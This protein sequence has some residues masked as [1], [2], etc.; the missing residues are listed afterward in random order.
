ME[1]VSSG[2]EPISAQ[3]FVQLWGTSSWKVQRSLHQPIASQIR[4]A[5]SPDSRQLA[6]VGG[7][8]DR[9]NVLLWDLASGRVRPLV[10]GL[11]ESTS[12]IVYDPHGRWVAFA[13]E[14]GARIVDVASGEALLVVNIAG[15]AFGSGQLL[16]VSADG[17]L[18]AAIRQDGAVEIW[19]LPAD[20]DAVN[21]GVRLDT[22]PPHARPAK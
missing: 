8:I 15:A 19:R 7:W 21:K 16:A 12:S 10:S 6:V 17:R 1:S 18:L 22:A 11:E 4:V 9:G 3:D 13:S 2:S 14:A 20:L 5:F